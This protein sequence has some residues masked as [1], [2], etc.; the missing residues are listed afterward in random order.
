[1]YNAPFQRMYVLLRPAAGQV[2]GFA[3]VESQRGRGR[4]SIHAGHLPDV[5]VR[6][7]LLAGEDQNG[8]VLD[9]G[10]LRPTEKHQAALCRDNIALHG[11]YHTLALVTDWPRARLLLYG[12]LRKQPCCTLWQMQET[13]AR[14]LAV[15]AAD[16][17]PA[18]A[19]L[20]RK[21]PRPSVLCLPRRVPT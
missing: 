20:P 13:V 5:P 9:L 7:L 11:G 8:A 18:P 10:L 17:A 15:P 19:E 4:L 14:Y 16:S 2:S 12:W 3:R 1:M 6:A 21:A